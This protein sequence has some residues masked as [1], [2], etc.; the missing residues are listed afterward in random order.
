MDHIVTNKPGLTFLAICSRF[1][2][3]SGY[4]YWTITTFIGGHADPKKK[5]NIP[6]CVVRPNVL[7]VHYLDF[8][9]R[10]ARFE[11]QGYEGDR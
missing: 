10:S 8:N 4:I 11:F 7:S 5:D 3:I 6:Y 1:T 2:H 9:I